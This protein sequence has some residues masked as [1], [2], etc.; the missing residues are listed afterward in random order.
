MTINELLVKLTKMWPL[1][2]TEAWADEYRNVLKPFAGPA[3]DRAWDALM[4][5]WEKGFPPRPADIRKH[6]RHER[7]GQGERHVEGKDNWAKVERRTDELVDD[8]FRDNPAIGSECA[9][10]IELLGLVREQIRTIAFS[11]AQQEALGASSPIE[12]AFR[13]LNRTAW[14]TG[15]ELQSMR[16]RIQAWAQGPKLQSEG[17]PRQ[18]TSY[19]GGQWQRGAA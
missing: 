6:C 4:A 19:V 11:A 3:L 7:K 15:A 8:W 13:R 12:A 14:L 18:V 1:G 17:G 5:T 16:E 10:S 9:A 2:G